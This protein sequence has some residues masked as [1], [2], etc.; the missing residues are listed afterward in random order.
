M[1][2]RIREGSQGT[3]ATVILG[4]VIFSFIFAGVGSYI[5]SSINSAA[6]TVNGQDISRDALEKAYQNERSRM[7]SQYGEAFAALAGDE[8]YLKEFRKGVLDRLISEKLIDQAALE[9]G[10]RVSDAQIKQAIVQMSE[11]QVDGK[12]DNDRYLIVLRTAGF[13]PN[14]FRDYMRIDMV[15]RQLSQALIGTEFA[16]SGETKRIYDLQAQTRDAKYL[17]VKTDDFAEQVSVT[18]EEINAYYQTNIASFDTEQ[19]VSVAYVELTLNDLLPAIEVTEQE[20]E[21]EYQASLADFKTDEERRVSH[22]LIEFGDDEAGAE[23]QAEDI[24]TQV[25]AGKDFAELAKEYSADTFS[26]EKGGDIDWFGKGMMDPAFE[27]SAYSLATVG[28]V[29]DVVKSDFGFHIIKLT[30]IKPENVTPYNDVKE[31][32]TT[33]VKIRKAETEL[34]AL[35]QRMAEVA[36][37]IPDH[38]DEVAAVANKPIVTTELFS[39]NDVPVALS[40]AKAT[41]AAF[42]ADLIE[43]GVN[44]DVLDLGDNRL[45]VLRVVNSEAERTKEL[46]EVSDSIKQILVK[47][48]AVVAARQWTQ[49]LANSLKSG[50]DITEELASQN[51]A[52]Q[53]KQA[54]A[55]T[56]AQLGQNVLTEL[57]KLGEGESNNTAVVDTISGDVTLVQLLKINSPVEPESML[58]DNFQ[59]RLASNKAQ[60]LYSELLDSLKASADIEIYN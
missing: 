38:L 32:L 15:R 55:R 24:L 42:D 22:I 49:T 40:S 30:D 16:L 4:L 13:Q 57:F 60:V 28:E 29:S 2:E 37:E 36:F 53:E 12:F 10:L 45:M 11:F 26:A 56:D 39:R 35:Q 47:E 44:S 51:I 52:W 6:A 41:N 31:Q 50:A 25:K 46:A 14:G 27:D 33:T 54:I 19:K 9:L 5:N 8:A 7:E 20:L 23:Q 3:W 43:Q 59:R 58:L 17:T 21:D 1:L 48:A 34:Y 18:D